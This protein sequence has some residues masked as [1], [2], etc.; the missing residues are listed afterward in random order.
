ME[1]AGPRGGESLLRD[2]LPASGVL[3]AMHCVRE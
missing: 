1:A 3:A 2:C